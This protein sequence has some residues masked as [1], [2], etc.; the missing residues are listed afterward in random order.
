MAQLKD[1][2]VSG[3]L[4]VSGDALIQ[5][6]VRVNGKLNNEILDVD[7]NCLI[8]D[9]CRRLDLSTVGNK[10]EIALP[11]GYV[12]DPRA[13]GSYT[14]TLYLDSFGTNPTSWTTSAVITVTC[15]NPTTSSDDTITDTLGNFTSHAIILSPFVQRYIKIEVTTAC[16][17]AAKPYVKITGR[18]YCH[19]E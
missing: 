9:V 2:T 5:G 15:Y 4:T 1:T 12:C 16:T 18:I 14:G 7:D 17:G 3:D 10:I 19:K 6:D 11:D 8:I 13:S